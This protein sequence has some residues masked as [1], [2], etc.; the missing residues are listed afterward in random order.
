M[1]IKMILIE[2]Y[3]QYLFKCFRVLSND[4]DRNKLV[5]IYKIDRASL[6]ASH[7]IYVV[8]FKGN[9]ITKECYQTS[10]KREV[11]PVPYFELNNKKKH[12]II[13]LVFDQSGLI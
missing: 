10:W 2:P 3:E 13:S 12:G 6:P 4:D 1:G 8:V 11:E 5:V 9:K 7:P